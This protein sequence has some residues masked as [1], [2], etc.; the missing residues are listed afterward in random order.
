MEKVYTDVMVVGYRRG[1]R[2]ASFCRRA[3]KP[4]TESQMDKLL[5]YGINDGSFDRV[6]VFV[7]HDQIYAEWK[8]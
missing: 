6:V 2:H 8:R 7:N 4:L 5:A 3:N 1:H